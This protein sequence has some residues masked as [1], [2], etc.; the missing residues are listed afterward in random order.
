MLLA[1]FLL[2]TRTNSFLWSEI[3]LHI[4][5]NSLKLS[6]LNYILLPLKFLLIFSSCHFYLT[7]KMLSEN[8][9][10]NCH[11]LNKDN[12]KKCFS[13]KIK[14]WSKGRISN[15][16]SCS[17]TL[18]TYFRL[19]FKMSNHDF[20]AKIY[21]ILGV[22]AKKLLYIFHTFYLLECFCKAKNLDCKP[23]CCQ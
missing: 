20:Q 4:F 22:Q 1:V 6:F 8:S 11:Q 23:L 18:H 15:L 7:Y 2:C 12:V 21:S 14:V 10:I 9:L 17:L 13:F 5:L 19:A 3:L 16:F